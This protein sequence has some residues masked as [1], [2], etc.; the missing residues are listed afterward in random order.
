VHIG[1][2]GDDGPDRLVDNLRDCL[3]QL[4]HQASYLG[5]G[6]AHRGG[7]LGTWFGEVAQ[8]ALPDL[9]AR[10][11]QRLARSALARG[12]DAVINTH[13]ALSPD[14][15]DTLRRNRVPVAL[16]FPDALT[17][18]GRQRVLTAPYTAMFFK[19][20]L[21]VER[22]R[23]M[24]DLPVWYLPEAC[25]PRWHRPV[26]A[27]GAQRTIV[28]VGN[29]Y[30][31]RLMLIRRLYDAGIPLT[32]YGAAPPRWAAGL[33]PPGIHTGRCVFREEKSAVFRAAAGV[34]NNLH[35]GEILGV[36][37]RLFEA[38]AAGAAVLCEERS[39]L[40]ELFDVDREV[41]AFKDF[42]GLVDRAGELL[43]D[44]DRTAEIG[45]AASKRAHAEHSY[46][47]RIPLILEK[48]A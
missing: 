11:H 33:L 13:A 47:T 3:E 28:V 4:G 16:Y 36:N 35:P 21:L 38:T 39:T 9:E 10:F 19:E 30:P 42:A 23:D 26:G 17:N 1:L 22:L 44:N 27:A 18:L 7:R 24:L 41:L 12:C 40:P 45:D 14:A 5:S 32:L 43:A 46:E 15:V 37:C 25:N 48:L 2:V 31:S 34:L 20:P 8:N 29:L 6:R